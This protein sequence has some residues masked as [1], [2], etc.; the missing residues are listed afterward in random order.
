[1]TVEGEIRRSGGSRRRSKVC[2]IDG[3]AETEEIEV[4]ATERV[5]RGGG[6]KNWKISVMPRTEES[7][8]TEFDA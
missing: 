6:K 3:G 1:M 8:E 5:A 2:V 4:D 7:E